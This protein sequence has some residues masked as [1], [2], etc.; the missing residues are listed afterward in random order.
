MILSS[1]ARARSGAATLAAAAAIATALSAPA[2]AEE[3]SYGGY[4]SATHPVHTIG[5]DPFFARVTEATGGELTWT[6][7][8]GG[9]MGG[10]K[11]LLSAIGD[12]I[13]D[14]GAVVDIYTKSS[15]PVSSLISGLLA[16]A[17]DSRL[18][19]AAMAEHE[20]LNCPACDEEREDNGVKA[21]GYYATSP[22]VLM[23]AEPVSSL[24][25]LNGKKVRTSSRFG[26]M[27]QGMGATAVSITSA[28]MYE[29][30][31]RGSTDC[32]VGPAA[33]LTSYNIKDFVR[34]VVSTPLGVY[35]GTMV[36]TMNADRWEDLEPE[37]KKAIID[38][39]PQ[40]T[41]DINWV[42]LDEADEAMAMVAAREDG[43]VVEASDDF[44]S[45]LA[46]F[47][48][49]EYDIAIKQGEADGIENA[50]EVVNSFRATV[51][52]W[53]KIMAEEVG[54]DKAKYVA[55]LK[56]EIYDKLDY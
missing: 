44:K 51:D 38:N 31:Q 34:S 27:M 46:A 6:T 20:L 18:Y 40:M 1:S 7:F 24:E 43:Q 39:I 48:E 32:A 42:Y 8:Y 52:K 26:A 2:G 4:I 41:A 36:L 15:L 22:Y 45:A 5:L 14:T 33:W 54:D 9:A 49:G 10:P 30:M 23:C 3:L 25:E 53:R 12:N 35:F 50:G 47:R 17:D 13:L 29:A 28:E 19:G 21:L 56:R 16:T 37:Y 11:E 55:A